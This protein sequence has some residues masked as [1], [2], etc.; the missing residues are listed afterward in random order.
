MNYVIHKYRLTGILWRT[1]LFLQ[2]SVCI[3]FMLYIYNKMKW[4]WYLIKAY[5]LQWRRKL[6]TDITTVNRT[7]CYLLIFSLLNSNHKDPW[8]TTHTH[9]H[10]HTYMHRHTNRSITCK[11]CWNH[12][13]RET[14]TTLLQS[15]CRLFTK[16]ILALR[17]TVL[18]LR[19]TNGFI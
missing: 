10:T 7:V 2:N 3:Y 16:R 17:R 14:A 12:N 9:T 6:Q 11:Y 18:L 19:L 8:N 15:R 5:K 1:F 13:L 4:K